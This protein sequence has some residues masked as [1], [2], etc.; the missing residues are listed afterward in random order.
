MI[1][2][3]NPEPGTRIY[4]GRVPMDI[5]RTA[6]PTFPGGVPLVY[7]EP[8]SGGPETFLPSGSWAYEPFGGAP[9]VRVA[10]GVPDRTY[11]ASVGELS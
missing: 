2:N 3:V 8:V 1:T 9:E 6:K 10:A 7:A 11:V 4:W 5:T